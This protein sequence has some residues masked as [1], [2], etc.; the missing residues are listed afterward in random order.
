MTDLSA[1]GLYLAILFETV[2]EKDRIPRIVGPVQGTSVRDALIRTRALIE[3][4]R[5]KSQVPADALPV[6]FTLTEL[7]DGDIPVGFIA[8]EPEDRDE[9]RLQVWLYP[10]D[11]TP[12]EFRPEEIMRRLRRGTPPEQR[13]DVS[14]LSGVKSNT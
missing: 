11:K 2:R 13:R 1:K 3:T 14:V 4:Q 5:K 8:V 12:T 6:R 7:E 10:V 9:P